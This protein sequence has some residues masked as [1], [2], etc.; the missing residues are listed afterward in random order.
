[1]QVASNKFLNT[2]IILES[3]HFPFMTIVVVYSSLF[4]D[5]SRQRLA[6]VRSVNIQ[7]ND[8]ESD[9]RCGPRFTYLHDVGF[10]GGGGYLR[11]TH[12]I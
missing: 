12:A 3:C 8:E 2:S 11:S 6:C 7:R 5:G 10:G 9:H 4:C 1:M